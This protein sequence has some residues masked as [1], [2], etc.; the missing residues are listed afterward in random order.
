[1]KRVDEAY[2]QLRREILGGKLPPGTALQEA[3]VAS[4]LGVSRTPVREALARLASEAL[5]EIAPRRAAR[6]TSWR[7][8]DEDEVYELRILLEGY[9]AEVATRQAGADDIAELERLCERAAALLAEPELDVVAFAENSRAFHQRL[10]AITASPRLQAMIS[11]LINV[12]DVVVSYQAFSPEAI[13]RSV[14][15]HSE[16]VEA[17]RAGNARWAGNVMQAHVS[18]A[19]EARTGRTSHTE[20]TDSAGSAN[21]ADKAAGAKARPAAEEPPDDASTAR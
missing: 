14:R 7:P 2:R 13:E 5:V 11:S 4:R 20:A 15:H 12:P 16:L 17:I 10:A 19:R 3:E 1:V 18:A 21:S 8:E 6:V 9:A